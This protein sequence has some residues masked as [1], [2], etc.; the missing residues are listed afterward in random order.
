MKITKLSF[1]ALT[2]GMLSITQAQQG[3]VGIN[4]S[5]PQ[6]TIDMRIADANLASNSKEGLLIPRVGRLR[7]DNMGP[8]VDQGTMVYINS[9]DGTASGRVSNVTKVGFYHFD[10]N[11]WIGLNNE[12]TPSNVQITPSAN[13]INIGESIN[14]N[15]KSNIPSQFFYNSANKGVLKKA[16]NNNAEL[17]S[18]F[19]V[20][21]TEGTVLN[22]NGTD[23]IYTPTATG[24]QIIQCYFFD[25][26]KNLISKQ[27][28]ITV[29]G[30]PG[31]ELITTSQNIYPND[32]FDSFSF[33]INGS[34]TTQY[35]YKIEKESGSP[36]I[37][38]LDSNAYQGNFLFGN[39]YDYQNQ[40]IEFDLLKQSPGVN[41]LKIS[42][43]KKNSVIIEGE[44][45]LKA[46]R[47]LVWSG[48]T[49]ITPMSKT[50]SVNTWLQLTMNY[51][52]PQELAGNLNI[53][54]IVPQRGVGVTNLPLTAEIRSAA[55]QVI[56]TG[57]FN[58]NS[59]TN[60]EISS[61]LPSTPANQK[62]TYWVRPTAT[63]TYII[64][65]RTAASS[66]T[67]LFTEY[68]DKEITVVLNVV[69]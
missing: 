64:R 36:F 55:G 14:L 40:P 39:W 12:R 24:Q 35:Q 1:A 4:T 43:R 10:G 11:E 25:S 38:W 68:G 33:E 7:A 46:D 49:T 19:T 56:S 13:A 69:P 61:Y 8:S 29:N 51:N 2:I 26:D 50:V 47:K 54:A 66:N 65:Y 59:T 28:P 20:V 22:P 30:T 16:V 52:I 32:L 53:A 31:Q 42:A 27:V 67:S 18:E 21:G 62:N 3:R 6:A 45:I 58:E 15:I 44:K 37:Y 41:S 48:S 34:G 9:L 23:F 5:N 63:G 60:F 57:T 17:I